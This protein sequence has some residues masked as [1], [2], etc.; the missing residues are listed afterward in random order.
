MG[1][2]CPRGL[3]ASPHQNLAQ[4]HKAPSLHSNSEGFA[5]AYPFFFL[6]FNTSLFDKRKFSDMTR[7]FEIKQY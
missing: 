2:R 7:E 4:L 5:C 1:K 6:D 3:V